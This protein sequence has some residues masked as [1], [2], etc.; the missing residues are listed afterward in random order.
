MDVYDSKAAV[1]RVLPSTHKDF[2]NPKVSL[3]SYFE[4]LE[5]G[6]WFEDQKIVKYIAT[7]DF[8]DDTLVVEHRE[9]GPT[10]ATMMT[11]RNIHV[12]QFAPTLHMI[13]TLN[14]SLIAEKQAKR[15]H[16]KIVNPLTSRYTKKCRP[17]QIRD[18]TFTCRK[19]I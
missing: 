7:F 13:Q 5:K 14:D 4:Y 18:A 19:I 8:V 16:G 15:I 17:G 11:D 3:Q 2:G 12:K 9:F 10:I 1:T 6:D